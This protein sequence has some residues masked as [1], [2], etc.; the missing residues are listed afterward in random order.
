MLDFLNHWLLTILIFLPCVGAA[1]VLVAQGRD[2][3]R[4]TALGTTI[5]TFLLSLLLFATFD[6]SAGRQPGESADAAAARGIYAYHSGSGEGVVQMVQRG[7]WIPA[8]NVEYLVGIDGLS[9]P[10]VILSTFICLL[11]CIA[12]WNIPK[13]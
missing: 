6:W 4:W 9:F 3:V 5:V 13:A 1:L 2:A 8:F 10:L 12:S 7:K 11:S